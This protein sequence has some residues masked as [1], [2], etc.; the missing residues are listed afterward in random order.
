MKKEWNLKPEESETLN[1]TIKYFALY[2]RLTRQR[3]TGN[4]KQSVTVANVFCRVT[5]Y[6]VSTPKSRRIAGSLCERPGETRV[7]RR[8]FP[9]AG[10]P[11][12][13]VAAITRL[14]GL[15]RPDY[16]IKLAELHAE[17]SRAKR[18]NVAKT[19][20]N[21]GRLVNTDDDQGSI[22]LLCRFHRSPSGDDSRAVVLVSLVK[23]IVS[24]TSN[25]IFIETAKRCGLVW[26]RI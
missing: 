13:E 23:V 16:S 2:P 26:S 18:F 15:S 19:S 9:A 6:R 8:K 7:T 4:K 11:V 14:R 24:L 25:I 12:A 1:S 10:S 5:R 22:V 17:R 3:E 20:V 21:I